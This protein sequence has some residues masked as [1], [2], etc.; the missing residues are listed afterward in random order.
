MRVE[1]VRAL[2]DPDV[3]VVGPLQYVFDSPDPP[4]PLEAR[5]LEAAV[6]DAV[7]AVLSDFPSAQPITSFAL[8]EWSS[9][10]PLL[11][12]GLLHRR[13]V[14]GAIVPAGTIAASC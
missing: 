13:G 12:P 8:A 5:V 4:S 2:E 10:P 7:A 3:L 14:A 6:A 1:L 9:S 11:M